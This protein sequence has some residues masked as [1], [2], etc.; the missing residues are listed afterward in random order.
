MLEF[1]NNFFKKSGG[2]DKNNNRSS[3]SGGGNC[4]S[5]NGTKGTKGKCPPALT[6][7]AAPKSP[8]KTIQYNDEEISNIIFKIVKAKKEG[9][10]AEQ[11]LNFDEKKA[12]DNYLLQKK[13][14]DLKF[15]AKQ[16]EAARIKEAA[17]I[18]ETRRKEAA[19]LEEI[20]RKEAISRK[21]IEIEERRKKLEEEK[22]QKREEEARQKLEAETRIK[23]EAA[24]TRIS[25]Y[26]K[27]NP[28]RADLVIKSLSK[29]SKKSKRSMGSKG[30]RKRSTR[31]NK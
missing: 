12:Y 1:L 4:S 5:S 9:L 2:S 8:P 22:K 25:I 23:E 31:R 21:K 24:N 28:S 17:R 18:E 3:K 14:K 30:G 16:E 27:A 26:K 29:K 11:V 13:E 6:N 19:K 10:T 15:K 20:R 7:H